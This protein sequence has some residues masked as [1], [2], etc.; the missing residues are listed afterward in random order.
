MADLKFPKNWKEVI[1]KINNKEMKV[2]DGI[3][4]LGISKSDYYKLKKMDIEKNI[5]ERKEITP[6][7]YFDIIKGSKEVVTSEDLQKSFALASNMMDGYKA[8]GQDTAAKKLSYLMDT[9]VKESRLVELGI[10]TFIY[11][12]DIERY[13][14]K[15]EKKTVKV[16]EVERYEREIPEEIRDVINL[17]KDIFDRLIIVFTDYTGKMEKQVE[18]ER[19][20][21]DPILF[22]YFCNSRTPLS[23]RFYYLGDWE[24]EYCDLTLESM[25]KEM[26]V[27]SG[28]NIEH[29]V[30]TP[31]TDEELKK[32]LS[33][34]KS[35]EE[36]KS[37]LETED[38]DQ[39]YDE[40]DREYRVSNPGEKIIEKIK[41]V[42]SILSKMK[43]G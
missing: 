21:K 19:R 14:N 32:R 31:Q 38:F 43:R 26:K 41:K 10:D 1:D 8:T 2:A 16:I 11:R 34:L 29:Q 40:T 28:E 5:D 9:I 18:K 30:H 33:E 7:E 6:L 25:V 36:D 13:I 22:G 17:T 27:L 35:K 4:A 24:D 23:D 20:E 42:K 12:Q 15:I 37:T 39:K 3:A